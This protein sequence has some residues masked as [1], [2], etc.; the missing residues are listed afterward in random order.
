[1]TDS[2]KNIHSR[3]FY[4]L[5]KGQLEIEKLDYEIMKQNF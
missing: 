3:Y 2:R 5:S 4:L 1:M